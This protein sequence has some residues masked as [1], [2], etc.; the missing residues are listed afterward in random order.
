MKISVIVPTYK[1]QNYIWECLDALCGQTLPKDAFEIIV[2]LNGP[3]EPYYTAIQAYIMNHIDCSISLLYSEISG[4]SHARNMA[5]EAMGGEYVM[6]I[7]DDDYL[8]DVCLEE[9][10][11]L[12]DGKSVVVC[13]PYAFK[14]GQPATQCKYRQTDAFDDCVQ[15]GYAYLNSPA[16]KLFVGPCMKLIPWWIIGERRFDTRFKISED[17]LFMF[18]ISDRITGI[19]FTDKRAIYYRRYREAS[20]ITSERIR[21]NLMNNI[22]CVMEYT[23]I[24]FSGNYSFYM[25]ITRILGSCHHTLV[26]VKNWLHEK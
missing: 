23:H 2:V 5:L 22:R 9:M 4:V 7:D 16:R 15:C 10:L 3:K 24:Y 11:A 25:Y 17:S 19:R 18:L 13:Y 12:S 21:E 1:P 20:A 26:C 6:F 8:S 14:D